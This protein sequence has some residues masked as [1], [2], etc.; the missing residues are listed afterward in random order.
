[1]IMLNV[2]VCVYRALM[3][4]VVG[5]G[6]PAW[7]DVEDQLSWQRGAAHTL[8]QAQEYYHTKYSSQSGHSHSLPPSEIQNSELQLFNNE[9][10]VVQL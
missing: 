3:P 2:L 7:S 8:T 9:V 6:R 1:M 10:R 4:L 5:V